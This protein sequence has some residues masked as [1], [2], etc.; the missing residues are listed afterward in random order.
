MPR[1]VPIAPVGS[2]RLIPGH[3]CWTRGPIVRFLRGYE[4]SIQRVAAG[5]VQDQPP[6]QTPTVT[7]SRRAVAGAPAALRVA[8]PRPEDRAEAAAAAD[9]RRAG[10]RPRPL[11]Q[12]PTRTGYFHRAVLSC[13]QTCCS[14]RL[15]GGYVQLWRFSTLAVG[16]RSTANPV[17]VQ[18]FRQ[19]LASN[20]NRRPQIRW[21]RVRAPPAP[22]QRLFFKIS[23]DESPFIHR[24]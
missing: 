4:Y 14:R 16:C 9:S 12:W 11:G 21:S 24:Y 18:R 17:A 15:F 5:T 7:D 10:R 19:S 2:V 13:R 1:A 20:E 23:F 8:H 22:L 3:Q 6:V